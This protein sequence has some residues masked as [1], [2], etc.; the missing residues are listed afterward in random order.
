MSHA[1]MPTATEVKAF[2]TTLTPPIAVNASADI[3]SQVNA[4]IRDW[5]RRSRYLPFFQTDAT[6]VAEPYDPPGPNKKGMNRGGIETLLL[7]NGLISVTSV[8]TSVYNGSVGSLQT[9]GVN[10][11]L[12]PSDA[13]SKGEP[14]TKIEF[15][16]PQWGPPQSVVIT[17]VWGYCS[18]SVPDDVWYAVLILAAS[19][20]LTAMLQGIIAGP[21]SIKDGDT[22]VSQHFD[23]KLGSA[24][25]AEAYQTLAG[26]RLM[27]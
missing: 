25:A 12:G 8:Y 24:L 13:A 27:N 7:R 18:G 20:V 11:F 17:G 4:A 5:S 26:Y 9:L 1:A 14:W 15:S 23:N 19:Y 21:D 3:T 2:L 16:A 22:T 6:P 10:Y